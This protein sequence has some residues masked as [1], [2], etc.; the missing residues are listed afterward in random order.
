MIFY[1]NVA[2][3]IDGFSTAVTDRAIKMLKHTLTDTRKTSICLVSG[4]DLRTTNT[5]H[6]WHYSVVN[7]IKKKKLNE[8][9]EYISLSNSIQ[10]C[11]RWS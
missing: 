6:N 11:K 5:R 4:K 9:S 8:T 7:K 3:A 1:R 10:I 2:K